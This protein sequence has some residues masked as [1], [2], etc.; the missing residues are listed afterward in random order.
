MGIA[1]AFVV[2]ALLSSIPKF[3]PEHSPKNFM[4]ANLHLKICFLG[5]PHGK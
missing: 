1:K 4:N 3:D 2:T 5:C